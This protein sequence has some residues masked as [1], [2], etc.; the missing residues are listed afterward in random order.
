MKKHQDNT[1]LVVLDHR[2]SNVSGPH[3]ERDS[4]SFKVLLKVHGLD[5][6]VLKH[7]RDAHGL[8][9]GGGSNGDNST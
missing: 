6:S 8:Q 3:M 7:D 5:R 4:R 2:N 9:G 1:H